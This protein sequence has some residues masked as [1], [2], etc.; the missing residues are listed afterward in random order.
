MDLLALVPY[1]F[2]TACAFVFGLMV[3]SFLNVLIARMPYEKSIVWPSSRCFVCYRPIRYLDNVP[4]LGYLRLRG[5][6]RQCGAKFSARYMWVELFTGLAFAAVFVVEA[7][8]PMSGAPWGGPINWLD[9]PALQFNF[10]NPGPALF[11]GIIVSAAH[12][13]LLACLIAA[14]VIDAK[15]RIIPLGITYTGT[16]IGL[17]VSTACPWP[18]PNAVPNIPPANWA[19]G[20]SIPL[21]VAHWPFWG[22]PPDWAP[23]GTPLFGF[24]T[25]LIGAGVGML[26]GRAIKILFEFGMGREALGMGD[27]DLLMMGG[28]FLGW[29]VIA[30]ALPV[31]AVLTLFFIIPKWLWAVVRRQKFDSALAFGPGLAAGVVACWFGW[32]WLGN[33]VRAVFFD[34]FM[35]AVFGGIAGGGLLIAGLLLRRK[36]EPSPAG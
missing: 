35:I 21:G 3:G 31:G 19:L 2:L 9:R 8:L 6:C 18:W 22:P 11:A 34:G 15:H 10:W 12:C 20:P 29:Q 5:K 14:A 36:P 1:L 7:L 23:A 30:L 27:A 4:I 32:P 17:I 16:V 25:G 33:L 13:V 26:I 28:A 24:L